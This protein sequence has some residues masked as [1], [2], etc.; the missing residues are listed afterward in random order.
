MKHG[1]SVCTC[2][3]LRA[4]WAL[5]AAVFIVPAFGAEYDLLLKTQDAKH[6]VSTRLN[7]PVVD[8]QAVLRARTAIINPFV[9]EPGGLAKGD[10]IRLDF[11]PDAIY[12]A[13]VER[14][15]RH[16]NGTF[17]V[18]AKL[19]EYPLS[20]LLISSTR[21]QCLVSVSIPEQRKEYRILFDF[22][23]GEHRLLELADEA[24]DVLDAAPS[25]IPPLNGAAQAADPVSPSDDLL[26]PVTIDLL[27]VYTPAAKTWANTNGGINNIIS[28][29]MAKAQLALDNSNTAITLRLVH[30]AQ[31][32]YTESGS[33][34][35]DLNRLTSKTDGHIDVVHA[36]RD[37]YG[38]DLVTLFT[39]VDDTGGIGWLLNSTYGSPNYAFCISRVQQ[40]SWTYTMIHELGHNMGCH[41]HK[42]QNTQPGPGLF[43][44][45]AGW[46]WTGSNNGKYC[47]V[48][49]YESGSYFAD[50]VTHTRVAYFS[51]PDITHLGAATGHAADGDNARTLREIKQVISGYRT[52]ATCH[53][54]HMDANGDLHVDA[55]DFD[56]F[57]ACYN[58]PTNLVEGACLCV[59]SNSD[60]YVDATDFDAF[61]GCYNGPTHPPGCS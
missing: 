35:Q 43:S 24:L 26:N 39:K 23:S 18:Q 20:S 49:T 50:G 28:Q 34:S 32:A 45:S 42:Q 25:L 13:T 47:S 6:G 38:A 1:R 37:L 10:E 36:W 54:P 7:V 8:S 44:Y 51:D 60:Q 55:V 9:A 2:T 40:V 59:D 5:V 29:A 41:H 22:W 17:S 46:R 53:T 27:I 11:F 48:M 52:S 15:T 31:V 14:V 61:S 16:I 58:G 30:T 4:V 3:G 57:S 12:T 33:S 19:A 56:F 21:G